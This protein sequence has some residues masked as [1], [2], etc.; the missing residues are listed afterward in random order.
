[1]SNIK[2]SIEISVGFNT[3]NS[4]EK[5]Y[6]YI[7]KAEIQNTPENREAK[8][9]IEERLHKEYLYNLKQMRPEYAIRK[10]SILIGNADV[11]V[12]HDDNDFSQ[13]NIKII[14]ECK[15]KNRKDGIE[16][17]KTYLAGCQTA[18]Y[19][20]WFNG[21]DIIYIKRLVKSP[22]WKIVYNIPRCGEKLDLPLKK[23]LKEAT[24]LV[25]VFESCGSC[26]EGC[27]II[28]N[29]SYQTSY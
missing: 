28:Y 3:S 19:G 15:R 26:Q 2:N 7:T 4:D 18:E 25:K 5:L 12:F 23:S 17:L 10:G 22:H 27:R 20:V 8:V 16:Q 21:E 6:D 13:E 11:V 14:V 1:M 9:I 29:F 24:E